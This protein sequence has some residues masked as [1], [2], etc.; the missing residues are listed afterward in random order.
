MLLNTDNYY[1]ENGITSQS[2][3][4]F[5]GNDINL[6]QND[7]ELKFND[8]FTKSVILTKSISKTY[9]RTLSFKKQRVVAPNCRSGKKSSLKSTFVSSNNISD[10]TK[11]IPKYKV[12]KKMSV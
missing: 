8:K 4:F 6:Y 12:T 3:D 2:N 10:Y 9:K 7:S 1:M 5:F 11:D